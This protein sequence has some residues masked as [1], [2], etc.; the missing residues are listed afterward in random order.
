MLGG[1][2]HRRDQMRRRFAEHRSRQGR[3]WRQRGHQLKHA[4]PIARHR[5]RRRQRRKFL[6]GARHKS[7]IVRHL[8]QAAPLSGS[9]VT[10]RTVRQ[11]A[12]ADMILRH[13]RRRRWRV[14]ASRCH[15]VL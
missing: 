1:T 9:P 13:Q 10:Y 7:R 14:G 8:L 6:R 3:P 2:L 15:C 11:L 4:T 12:A 5:Q